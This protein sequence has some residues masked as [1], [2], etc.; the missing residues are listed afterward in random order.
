MKSDR[1]F[2]LSFTF[3]PIPNTFW[4]SFFPTWNLW[5]SAFQRRNA[6]NLDLDWERQLLL[7]IGQNPE[8]QNKNAGGRNAIRFHFM[9]KEWK[10][11]FVL[12]YSGNFSFSAPSRKRWFM[13]PAR[14]PTNTTRA[15]FARRGMTLS[16][17][18]AVPKQLIWIVKLASSTPK[19]S[20][21]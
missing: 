3:R 11:D 10:H 15:S 17:N 18:C 21:W 13:V 19:I 12:N 9:P 5:I 14:E 7:D 2:I 20:P 1:D 16:L 4:C 8:R 6:T